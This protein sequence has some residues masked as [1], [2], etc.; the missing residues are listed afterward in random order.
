MPT[1]DHQTLREVIQSIVEAVGTPLA[2]AQAVAE[3]LVEA[4]LMNVA[5]E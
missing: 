3:S 4:N 5:I 2:G 1:I